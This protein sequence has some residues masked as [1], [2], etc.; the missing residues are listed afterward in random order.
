MYCGLPNLKHFGREFQW[1]STKNI[2]EFGEHKALIKWYLSFYDREN[3]S[4]LCIGV[5]M[6]WNIWEL[7][8]FNRSI[9]L[10]GKC[11]PR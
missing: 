3:F 9:N 11:T 7:L 2:E 5:L 6:S 8:S 1:D 10:E 4:H